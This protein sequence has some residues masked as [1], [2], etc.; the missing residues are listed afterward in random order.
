M[1]SLAEDS[2]RKR[3]ASSAPILGALEV[4]RLLA[5]FYI[6]LA[7]HAVVGLLPTTTYYTEGNT[8]AQTENKVTPVQGYM[9][10]TDQVCRA[11]QL[12]AFP[13]PYGRAI[14]GDSSLVRSVHRSEPG[15]T[16]NSLRSGESHAYGR[17]SEL[18]PRPPNS[19]QNLPF[20]VSRSIGRGLSPCAGGL[21]VQDRLS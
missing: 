19:R 11:L 17:H 10:P 6:L 4:V 20:P 18:Y 3:R 21:S 1:L 16:W 8:E 5:N 14:S 12:R 2:W 7:F 9:A 13:L 15:R